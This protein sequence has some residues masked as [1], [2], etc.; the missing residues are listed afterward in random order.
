MRV[1]T[2]VRKAN[3]EA[4]QAV[5]LVVHYLPCCYISLTAPLLLEFQQLLEAALTRSVRSN[6]AFGSHPGLERMKPTKLA[7]MG[8]VFSPGHL[9][10]L[11]WQ[12]AQGPSKDAP[13]L[14]VP[15]AKA[16]VP[17]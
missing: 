5:I 2:V 13:A 16:A 3:D 17:A 15:A 7:S 12:T 10:L 1:G 14:G 4:P 8:D 11:Y 9:A 6:A